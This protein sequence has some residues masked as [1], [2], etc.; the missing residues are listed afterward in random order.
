MLS[1]NV[2]AAS[3]EVSWQLP[4][5]YTDGTPISD[6]AGVKIYWGIAS[7]NYTHI[8]DLQGQP[9]NATIIV[10]DPTISWSGTSQSVAYTTTNA[11]ATCSPAVV[12]AATYYLNGT[13]YNTSG[14][15]SDFCNEVA[16]APSSSF[17]YGIYWG[18]N[19]NELN[20]WVEAGEFPAIT[21]DREQYPRRNLYAR[22]AAR[23]GSAEI[24]FPVVCRIDLRK[25]SPIQNWR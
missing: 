25:P 16:K 15:D 22:W 24:V 19:Q 14:L 13:C 6:L 7:S 18:V 10:P 4:S 11:V 21:L 3:I 5:T 1:A 9:T 2:Q 17:R 8:V 23:C 12:N 20:T